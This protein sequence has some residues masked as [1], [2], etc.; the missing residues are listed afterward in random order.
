VEDC[1]YTSAY[2]R[3][4]ERC[5]TRFACVLD[6]DT[7][8]LD[9]LDALIAEVA[10][11]R[12]DLI[13]VEER[14]RL[15]EALAAAWPD[16]G[17]WLRFAPGAVASNV[18]IFDWQA[19]RQRWGLRGIFGARVPGARHFDFDY[20]IG[21]RL[22]RHRYLRPYHVARYGLGTLLM[23][24]T[25]AVA[26]HQW[27]GAHRTRLAASASGGRQREIAAAGEAAFLHDYPALDLA[28]PTP[29][30]APACDVA[31]EQQ[32]SPPAP[33]ASRLSGLRYAV[34][35]EARALAA[36]AVVAW[37]RARP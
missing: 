13:G 12:T 4:L 21:Q 14:I 9:T 29:A 3:L 36:R 11:G 15:P 32:A 23:D 18:L 2:L 37:Q 34:G 30:W 16:S 19:F 1:N 33:P 25:R 5:E 24:G 31:R 27:Y 7:V 26:W 6:H 22:P 35:L 10:S 8:L 28:A 17:G 20:G